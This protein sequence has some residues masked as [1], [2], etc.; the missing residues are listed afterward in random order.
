MPP[1]EQ[2]GLTVDTS[3]AALEL[4]AAG[5]GVALVLE[6]FAR[7]F[8]EQ[9]RIR[10]VPGLQLPQEQSHYLLTR[11]GLNAPRAEAMLF[12]D[13]LQHALLAEREILGTGEAA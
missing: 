1:F 4:A 12:C 6:R 2:V 8:I 3:L 9:G 10:A 13:W 5:S 7:P 11:D